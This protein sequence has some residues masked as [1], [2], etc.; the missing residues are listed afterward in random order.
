M[1]QY[2]EAI[3]SIV[4]TGKWVENPRTGTL[5]LTKI[6]IS[7]R[8]DVGAGEFPIITTRKVNWKSAIAELLGYLRGYSSAAEFRALGCKTWDANANENEAWLANP[9]RTG[10]DDMGRVYGVQGREWTNSRGQTLDQLQK[11]YDD[12]KAGEDDRGEILTFWNPGEFDQGCL[13]PCLHTHHF[14][15]LDGELFLDSFQR[16]WD[17]LLGGVFNNIQCYALLAIM[18]QITGHKAGV[19]NHHI[20][21]AHIYENQLNVLLDKGQLQREPKLGARLVLSPD[22]KTLEDVL[23]WVTPDNFT[24][25]NYDPA[26]S[27]VYPFSV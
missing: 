14:S 20:V 17:G 25:E 10:E 9:N 11:I 8:Y 19:A 18:A 7:Q 16:S 5:C 22:I 26:E 6:G 3:D 15:L 21:N 2:L 13:R 27:I 23:T 4:K 12:L 24:V 1:K